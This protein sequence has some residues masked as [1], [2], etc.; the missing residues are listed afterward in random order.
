MC[1]PFFAARPQPAASLS[2]KS[3]PV[4]DGGE[5]RLRGDKKRVL[6]LLKDY[7]T[8]YAVPTLP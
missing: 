5:R 8:Y 7:S 6:Y 1:Q 3:T 2:Q 4:A